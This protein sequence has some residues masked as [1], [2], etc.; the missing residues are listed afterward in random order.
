[1]TFSSSEDLQPMGFSRTSFREEEVKKC[2]AF[3]HLLSV[4]RMTKSENCSVDLRDNKLKRLSLSIFLSVLPLIKPLTQLPHTF[5]RCA[6]HNVHGQWIVEVPN[7]VVLLKSMINAP[8]K[9]SLEQ[10]ACRPRTADYIIKVI[11][12][13]RANLKSSSHHHQAAD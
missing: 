8:L 3:R 6:S 12:Q 10:V 2:S 4:P 13:Q 1:M 5:R 7:S 9:R 11:D